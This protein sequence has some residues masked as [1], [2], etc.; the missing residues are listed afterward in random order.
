MY[1]TSH[2]SNVQWPPVANGCHIRQ[3]S[4]RQDSDTFLSCSSPRVSNPSLIWYLHRL[5]EPFSFVTLSSQQGLRSGIQIIPLCW[6]CLQQEEGKGER[7]ASFSLF[8]GVILKLH[9]SHC[10]ELSCMTTQSCKGDW[11]ISSSAAD[12][13]VQINLLVQRKATGGNYWIGTDYSSQE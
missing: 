5:K 13:Y 10:P 8:E 9:T 4:P 1:D 12:T 7:L 6:H 11:G 3:C 2:I